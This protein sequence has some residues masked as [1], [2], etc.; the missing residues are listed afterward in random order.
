MKQKSTLKPKA[1][2]NS[3][4]TPKAEKSN[5]NA[6]KREFLHIK[7][8][9][10]QYPNNL[11]MYS[12]DK[13]NIFDNKNILCLTSEGYTIYDNKF[14]VIKRKK[15]LSVTNAK[16]IDDKNFICLI[17]NI[18]LIKINIETGIHNQLFKFPYYIKKYN[19]LKIIIL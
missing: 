18:K 4:K 2:K 15:N 3:I 19:I 14:K 8:T 7:K 1:I 10:K 16:I 17:D 11:R 13:V 6:K 12:L 9:L 5:K